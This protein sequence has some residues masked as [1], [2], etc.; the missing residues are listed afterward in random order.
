MNV[1]KTMSAVALA[2]GLAACGSSS[3]DTTP[4]PAV[5]FTQPAGT[6]AVNFTV[7]DSANGTWKTNEL[8]WKGEVNFDATTRIATRDSTW[9]AGTWAK[10]YDDGPW[11]A[12]NA[13]TGQP[14][15]EPVGSVAGDHKLGITV[16]VAPPATGTLTFGYGLRDATNA[17]RANG[18]WVWVGSNGSFSVA[19]GA[20]A[21][22]TAPGITFG[23][24]GAIDLQLTLNTAQ[25]LPAFSY[26]AG[27]TVIKVKGSAWGWSDVTLLDD[28]TKGDA[29]AGDGIFTLVLS[30]RINTAA[31]PY[32]GLLKTGDKAEFVWV[33]DGVEYKDAAGAAAP[34]GAAGATK[35]GSAGWATQPVLKTTSGF[36]N[37]YILA[38]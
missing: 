30:Q 35:T 31:P 11:T 8:E 12:T 27:T 23:A 32:P 28:G 38:P 5:G 36:I 16:F 15:H 22:V 25:L 13:T 26:T 9:L 20:T 37:T 7:D 6:V 17:D 2:A 29:T 19:A 34:E 24:K 3:N 1:L 4:P 18:G 33:I 21:P 14:G 10:L